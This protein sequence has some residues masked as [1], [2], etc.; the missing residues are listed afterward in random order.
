[1]D[2]LRE[3]GLAEKAGSGFD[4]IFTDLLKKGKSLPEPEETD[5]SVIFRIK[6]DVVTEKLIELV[7][8]NEI[9]QTEDSRPNCVKYSRI[10]IVKS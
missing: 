4:K 2:I 1:M 6:S 8:A 9:V 7:A 3:I 10:R 5:T